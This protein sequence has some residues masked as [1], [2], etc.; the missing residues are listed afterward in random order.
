M[1]FKAQEEEQEKLKLS[2]LYT[3]VKILSRSSSLPSPLP[4]EAPPFLLP[5]PFSLYLPSVL[6]RSSNFRSAAQVNISTG[7]KF[8]LRN[9]CRRSWHVGFN[10]LRILRSGVPR[11]AGKSLSDL[12]R[13]RNSV[14]VRRAREGKKKVWKF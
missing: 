10:K 9:A 8:R 2:R 5:S 3:L 1:Q 13:S 14:C 11:V 12:F 7:T 6:L 4:V